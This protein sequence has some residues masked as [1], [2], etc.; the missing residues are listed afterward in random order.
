MIIL[1]YEENKISVSLRSR[2]KFDVSEIAS[3]LG[4]GGH[5][6]SSGARLEG[7]SFKEAVETILKV[8]REFA[9]NE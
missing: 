3:A 4:G 1:E 5:T 2:T 9:K 6:V 7:L 8:A